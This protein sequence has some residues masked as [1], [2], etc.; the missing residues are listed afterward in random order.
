MVYPQKPLSLFIL[1]AFLGVFALTVACAMSM[2]PEMRMTL[3]SGVAPGCAINQLSTILQFERTI[4]SVGHLQG[5]AFSV[6]M[7]LI[8]LTTLSQRSVTP[9]NS[10]P[11]LQQRIVR[12]RNS[13]LKI[14][15]ALSDALSRGIVQPKIY[16]AVTV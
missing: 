13:F 3:K 11:P 12:W 10:G 8:V 1:S 2:P 14:F 7:L 5:I 4:I 15:T 9:A 6:L 16:Q